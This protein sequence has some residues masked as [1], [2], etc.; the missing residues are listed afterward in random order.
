ME[1]KFFKL[2]RIK[3][4]L[5]KFVPIPFVVGGLV[6]FVLTA[7]NAPL[8]VTFK[9]YVMEI[10]APV[11]AVVSYPVQFVQEK[12]EK[13]SAYF[14]V[15]EENARLKSENE[16]LK[17]WQKLAV[18]LA[19][20]QKELSRLLNYKPVAQGREYVVRVL[21]DYNSPFTQS[22]IINGG[23]NIDVKKGDVLVTNDGLLGHVIEVG[24]TTARA[25]KV[26]D[27]YSR[28][29]VSVGINRVSGIMTGDNTRLPKIIS[30]P[31]EVKIEVDDYVM[32]SGDA[33]VYPSG[34]PVGRVV[35][36]EN[37]EIAV[38][39]FE[40]SDNLEFVR[41]IDFGLKGLL[42]SE[43]PCDCKEAD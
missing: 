37:G 4:Q 17:S 11:I 34:I 29:P 13:I 39:L 9:T 22:L 38:E 43:N 28:L 21:A 18:K 14:N 5:K 23:K 41:A 7:M 36:V 10:M 19:V 33:G 24:T 32:T 1:N 26:T 35:S 27:Y 40:K 25:L 3:A 6:L 2:Q 42:P 31:E 15:Y 16:V 8:M 30:L 20:D 12:S